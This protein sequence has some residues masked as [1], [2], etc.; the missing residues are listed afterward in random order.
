[1]SLHRNCPDI[2]LTLPQCVVQN[3]LIALTELGEI[4]IDGASSPVIS[5]V[6]VTVMMDLKHE[7]LEALRREGYGIDMGAGG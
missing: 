1:M 2:R 7:I 4:L 6:G 3:V 5:P